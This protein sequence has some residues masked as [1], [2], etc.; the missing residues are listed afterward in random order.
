MAEGKESIGGKCSVAGCDAPTHILQFH[1]R[2][3]K[4]SRAH[5]VSVMV[6]TSKPQ[7]ILQA[8]IDKCDLYCPNHHALLHSKWEKGPN[9]ETPHEWALMGYYDPFPPEWIKHKRPLPEPSSS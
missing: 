9:G 8:E 1:H 3:P 4:E 5:A 6:N 7:H 2:I